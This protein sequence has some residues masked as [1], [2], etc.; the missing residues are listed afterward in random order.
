M[1]KVLLFRSGHEQSLDGLQ[2]E[3]VLRYG[4]EEETQGHHDDLEYAAK[5]TKEIYDVVNIPLKANHLRLEE[6]PRLKNSLFLF[7]PIFRV[8]MVVWSLNPLIQ[9]VERPLHRHE[10]AVGEQAVRGHVLY[11]A[12]VHIV[13]LQV[14][15]LQE[16]LVQ[17]D[18]LSEHGLGVVEVQIDLLLDGPCLDGGVLEVVVD[19]FR[20]V[21][22]SALLCLV[23]ASI[24]GER[25][26]LDM[27]VTELVLVCEFV[28]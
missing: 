5:V 21:A 4:E 26:V 27:L 9:L 25:D 19:L 16:L 13:S 1:E 28:I 3:Q 18:L 14:V 2:E 23:F 22:G 12:Q 24:D 6:A 11:A 8:S 15:I 20:C 17:K 10:G 7:G